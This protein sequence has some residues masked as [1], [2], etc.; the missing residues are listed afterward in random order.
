MTNTTVRRQRRIDCPVDGDIVLDEACCPV[1]TRPLE[2]CDGATQE[3]WGYTDPTVMPR[4]LCVCAHCPTDGNDNTPAYQVTWAD[5]I[6]DVSEG[7]CYRHEVH[8][9]ETARLI[10]VFDPDGELIRDLDEVERELFR[11][12]FPGL[13]R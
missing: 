2:P 13:T 1:C 7:G 12:C 8:R 9:T 10:G 4:S 3:R 5:R 11:I 6:H